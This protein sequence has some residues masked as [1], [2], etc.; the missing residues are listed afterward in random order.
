MG[1]E[2]D[3]SI[4]EKIKSR[5]FPTKVSQTI[6][7]E[8]QIHQISGVTQEEP[9]DNLPAFNPSNKERKLMRKQAV[10]AARQQA[11]DERVKNFKESLV[12]KKEDVSHSKA[13]EPEQ[14]K[15]IVDS[16]KPTDVILAIRKVNFPWLK[17]DILSFSE[18]HLITGQRIFCG[19]LIPHNKVAS[20]LF[21]SLT[22]LQQRKIET[23]L[24]NQL[25][26][27]LEFGY[28][29]DAKT[30]RNTIGT[31]TLFQLGNTA[32]QRV[33]FILERIGNQKELAVIRV[34]GYDKTK[35]DV[36]LGIVTDK[37]RSFLKNRGKV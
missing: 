36:A 20:Q 29:K 34:L 31:K 2:S 7:S 18:I 11:K 4:F 21:E 14:P 15:P 25:P 3:G 24:Y 10:Q 35:Q 32:G 8:E 23:M 13:I 12:S 33:V 27:I 26:N 37:S 9:K 30:I 16:I 22:P 19:D 1:T 28:A 5:F 6:L 17:D